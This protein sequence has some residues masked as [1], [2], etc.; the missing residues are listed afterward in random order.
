MGTAPGGTRPLDSDG[1]PHTVTRAIVRT[2]LLAAALVLLFPVLLDGVAHGAWNRIVNGM[3]AWRWAAWGAC[4]VAM[5]LM[6][7]TG[8]PRRS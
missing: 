1:S 7:F 4:F 8:G 2:V 6:R 5:T 3:G